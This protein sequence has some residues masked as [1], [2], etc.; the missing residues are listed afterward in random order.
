[1]QG[2][3]PRYLGMGAGGFTPDS[4]FG[5]DP[6][7]EGLMSEHKI[8]GSGQGFVIGGSDGGLGSSRGGPDSGAGQVP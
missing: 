2:D 5:L 8:S 7:L 3:G 6:A 4:G 1:M